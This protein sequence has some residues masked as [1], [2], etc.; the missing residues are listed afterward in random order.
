MSPET[1]AGCSHGQRQPCT[2]VCPRLCPVFLRLTE[3]LAE[4]DSTQSL[5]HSNTDAALVQRFFALLPVAGAQLV[6]LQC[7]QNSQNFIHIAAHAQIMD[8]QP[9]K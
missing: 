6:S 9:A 8:G 3:T 1:R 7:V 2:D 4:P 5:V